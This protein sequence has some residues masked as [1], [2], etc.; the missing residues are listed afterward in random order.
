MLLQGASVKQMLEEYTAL[1]RDKVD[2][3]P[4]YVGAFLEGSRAC[5][6]VVTAAQPLTRQ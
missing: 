3:A 2:L 6:S 5:P 4:L 1:T